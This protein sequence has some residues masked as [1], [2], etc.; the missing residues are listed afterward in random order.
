MSDN[1]RVLYEAA[2]KLPE[3]ERLLLVS[4]IMETLPAAVQIPSVDDE[5]LLAELDR[6][7]SDSETTITW[8]EL[9]AEN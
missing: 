7:F 3:K 6:R 8:S 4:R 9:E 1:A 2:I 5:D